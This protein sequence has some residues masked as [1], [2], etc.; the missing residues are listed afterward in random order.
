M[1]NIEETLIYEGDFYGGRKE[2]IGYEKTLD[3]KYNGEFNENK[4][5]GKGEILFLKSE[6]FFEGFFLD[7]KMS[8]GKYTWKENGNYYQGTFLNNKMDGKGVYTTSSGQVYEGEY[9]DGKK[10]G[11]GIIKEKNK[12]IYEGEFK[13]G[14]P[15]G[16]GFIYDKKGN[17]L[18]VTMENGKKFN[19]KISKSPEPKKFGLS[20]NNFLFY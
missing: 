7:N 8:V 5:N 9:K 19:E 13:G 18:E 17:K 3:H 1:F 4:K 14:N 6:D 15:H 2:G 11:M 16:K 10:E 12:P 20:K